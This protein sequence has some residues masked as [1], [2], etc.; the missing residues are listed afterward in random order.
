[1]CSALALAGAAGARMH[2]MLD[3]SW[4]FQQ[5]GA[6]PAPPCANPDTA[7]P[8]DLTDKQCMGLSQQPQVRT[9]AGKGVSGAETEG[10]VL[11]AAFFFPLRQRAPRAAIAVLRDLTAVKR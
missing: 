2:A 7:F 4:K 3:P 1:M 8:I 10:S 11:G 9:L 5:K 6:G